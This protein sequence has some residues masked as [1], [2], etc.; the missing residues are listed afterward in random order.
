MHRPHRSDRS[1]RGLVRLLDGLAARRHRQDPESGQA[2]TEFALILVPLLILV[3][4]IIQFGIGL[5]YWLDMNRIANQGARYAVVNNWPGCER[6]DAAGTCTNTA[7]CG[8][9]ITPS[10]NQS[11][12]SYLKCQ[13]LTQGLRSSANPQV[14]YPNDGD[15]TNDGKTGSPVRVLLDSPYTFRAVMKL[16]TINLRARADMRLE[17]NT[18]TSLPFGH[19]SGVS[20]CTASQ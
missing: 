3:V 11:L 14:C 15:A 4:G 8:T 1:T 5:N 9:A 6:T 20:A 12:V 19:L 13:A 17:Q 2:T 10:T 18:T 16:G 7:A